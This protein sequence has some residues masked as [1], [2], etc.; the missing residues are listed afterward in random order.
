[1]SDFDPD[2][3]LLGDMYEYDYLPNFLVDKIKA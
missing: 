3:R 2:Y 1:M